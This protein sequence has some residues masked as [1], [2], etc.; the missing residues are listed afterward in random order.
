M[1]VVERNQ[2]NQAAAAGESGENIVEVNGT[3]TT[4]VD[5]Y[6][7]LVLYDVFKGIVSKLLNE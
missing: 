6:K 5:E 7:Q 1:L 3:S 2:S 4:I